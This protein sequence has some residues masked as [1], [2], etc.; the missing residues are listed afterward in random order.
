MKKLCVAIGL[1]ALAFSALAFSALAF[2]ALAFCV[3]KHF[4]D[5]VS[6]HSKNTVRQ[7]HHG[8]GCHHCR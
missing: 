2:S 7:G 6:H 1:A 8:H 5:G 4:P 3:P